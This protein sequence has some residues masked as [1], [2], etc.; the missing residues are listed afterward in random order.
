MTLPAR[1]TTS[2]SLFSKRAAGNKRYD[3]TIVGYDGG[4]LGL[5][6]V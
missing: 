4:T 6:G 1:T 3:I 5:I 2:T